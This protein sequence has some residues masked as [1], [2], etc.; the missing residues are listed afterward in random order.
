VHLLQLN[1]DA[2]AGCLGGKFLSQELRFAAGA[3]AVR[4]WTVL[5]AG[6]THRELPRYITLACATRQDASGLRPLFSKGPAAVRALQ[7][8]HAPQER[9]GPQPVL[10]QCGWSLDRNGAI[11][12]LEQSA[13][14]EPAWSLS[15]P[16]R[17]RSSAGFLLLAYG[18]RIR[19][20][21][22]TQCLEFSLDYRLKR[23]ASIFPRPLPITNSVAL[24]ERLHHR[25][26]SS[27]RPRSRSCLERLNFELGS[28]FGIAPGTWV[29]LHHD[30]R[31]DWRRMNP[32]NRKMAVVA[33]D[34]ARHVIETSE[35]L[36]DAW[37]QPGVVVM[38]RPERWCSRE[39]LPDFLALLDRLFP[40]LQFIVR[41]D[42]FIARRF[43][44]ALRARTLRIPS[45]EP[46][47]IRTA[48]AIVP[49]GAV[50]LVDVDGRL[51][52]L[53]LMKLGSHYKAE[54]KR[55][56]LSRLHRRMPPADSVLASCVFS[57]SS[58]HLS[59][60]QQ[61]YG[62]RLQ[63]GG[64]GFSLQSRLPADIENL[65]PDFSLYPKLG[66]RAIG[67]LT[68]G[69]PRRCPFCIV[70][71]K[72]GKPRLVS[73]LDSLLQG[74]RKLILLDDNLLAHPDADSLL[75]QMA[76]R[77]LEVNFNQTLDLR[78]LTAHR[79][80]LLR[81]IHCANVKFSRR[82]YHFSLND[83]RGLSVVRDRLMLLEPSRRDN[84]EFIC[85]YGFRTTLAEDLAR[86]QFL[87]SLPRTYVFVQ[88]YQPAPGCPPPELENFFDDKADENLDALVKVVFPQNMKSM[89]VYYRWVCLLYAQQRG[90]IHA[91]LVDTLFRY[92]NRH[93][94]G[95]FTAKLRAICDGKQLA[96]E[97]R[98]I[99]TPSV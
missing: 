81:Q 68:R 91:G 36:K 18:A 74:R 47:P 72:E 98:T 88:R 90:R 93:T 43:P 5:P 62:E 52:N 42:A 61:R 46:R 24:L 50:L 19:P 80:V 13:E 77:K 78:L 4:K 86:F 7:V 57:R 28:W 58:S 97:S 22:G 1:I 35:K 53:A 3:D 26:I 73:N 82:C 63:L 41:T 16:P 95:A 89:E 2:S 49:R 55:V 11:Q 21:R 38:D 20:D 67:F 75:A 94:R 23:V 70:P 30:F 14:E 69:C 48:P 15:M 79:A 27:G 51:P 29:S 34:I 59:A 96:G 76:E 32:M 37:L 64:S 10:R 33:L 84:V 92:N 60:L 17:G 65:Q 9:G 71:L 54:G 39:D 6:D 31:R 40:E 56:V 87:R 85:M 66:D 8:W 45:V 25:G 83:A 12:P 44:C 99:W